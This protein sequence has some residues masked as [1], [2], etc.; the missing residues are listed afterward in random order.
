MEIQIAH[1]ITLYLIVIGPLKIIAP[2]AVATANADPSLTRQIANKAFV[3]S[4][5]LRNRW[6]PG[7]GFA[8]L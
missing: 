8:H 3:H 4:T 2:F 7:E 6:L 5:F 1:L